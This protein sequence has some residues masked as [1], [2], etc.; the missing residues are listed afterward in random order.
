MDVRDSKKLN[1][2]KKPCIIISASGMM[3]AGRIKHHLANSIEN[4]RNTILVVGYC[5][6][7]TL[8]A[9]I[10]R[11]DKRVSIFGTE[12]SVNA[13]IERI[14]SYSGHGDYQEMM[15]FLNCQDK[16]LLKGMYL[17]HGEHEAQLFYKTK[18]EN[19]GFSHIEIPAQGDEVML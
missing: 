19:N 5:A 8:G 10:L 4:P 12:Y 9:R 16:S 7:P 17:V 11:G 1:E 2:I 15:D 13:T 6:P 3:E 14:E 18:L